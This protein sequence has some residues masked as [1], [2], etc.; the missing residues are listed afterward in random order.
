MM[1]IRRYRP[2]GRNLPRHPSACAHEK[3]A[4]GSS[5]GFQSRICLGLMLLVGDRL[6][7]FTPLSDPR[8][9]RKQDAAS[10]A[11]LGHFRIQRKYPWFPGQQVRVVEIAIAHKASR[12][13]KWLTADWESF[14]S[15]L[16]ISRG[17]TSSARG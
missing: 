13:V 9:G 14:R 2:G 15:S 1:P 4:F 5:A 7:G 10:P 16:A 3:R 6:T 8:L 17:Q 11:L 12:W